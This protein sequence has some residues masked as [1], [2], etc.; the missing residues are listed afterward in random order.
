[1]PRELQ[2]WNNVHVEK[3]NKLMVEIIAVLSA[4]GSQYYTVY[5]Y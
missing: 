2:I 3:T 4:V 5:A 1:M